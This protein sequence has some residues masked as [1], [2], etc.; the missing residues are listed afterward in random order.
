MFD[1]DNARE[2]AS[3]Y[4]S[5]GTDGSR[6]A[7]LSSCGTVSD[8][9]GLLKDIKREIRD[10]LGYNDEQTQVPTV[11]YLKRLKRWL[12]NEHLTACAVLS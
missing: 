8:P 10:D 5:S 12:V 11:T 3:W 6:F 4:H 1:L 2:V 7:E 9:E